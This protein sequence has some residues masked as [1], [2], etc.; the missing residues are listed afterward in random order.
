MQ[1]TETKRLTL[2]IVNQLQKW[3]A[4]AALAVAAGTGLCGPSHAQ[5]KGTQAKSKANPQLVKKTLTIT[6][7]VTLKSGTT[8]GVI[9]AQGGDQRGYALYL[10]DSKPNF[11]VRQK[12]K[13]Y[14]AKGSKVAKGAFSM[15]AHL[16]K[17]GAM[18]LAVNGVSVASGKAPGLFALQPKDGLSVGE[19]SM[20][21]V[22]DYKAPNAL[23]GKVE[24]VKITPQ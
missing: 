5:K 22:G 9:L 23:K 1:L 10:K 20:S 2:F 24:N 16:K 18:T 13:I 7:K 14:I 3:A 4:I 6:C 8:T 15:E 11:V 19:D 21:P 17:D 12:G